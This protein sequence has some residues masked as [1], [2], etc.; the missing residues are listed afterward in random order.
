MQIVRDDNLRSKQFG[1]RLDNRVSVPSKNIDVF[2][3]EEISQSRASDL[4]SGNISLGSRPRH[5]FQTV[6]IILLIPSR[7]V[8]G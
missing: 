7:Q 1:Y 8:P 4:L 3:F 2:H 6:F 5:S